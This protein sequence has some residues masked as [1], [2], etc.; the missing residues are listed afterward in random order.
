MG[1]ETKIAEA[2]KVQKGC[3]NWTWL[4][5][6]IPPIAIPPYQK[7]NPINIE[8]IPRY[9]KLIQILALAIK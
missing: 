2:N 9:K 5:R 3:N 4:T 1:S 8:K 7:K 6:E